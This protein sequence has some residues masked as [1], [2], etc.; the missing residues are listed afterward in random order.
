MKLLYISVVPVDFDNIAGVQRKVLSQARAFAKLGMDVGLLIRSKGRIMLYDIV[1]ER[2]INEYKG[3][4]KYDIYNRAKGIIGDYSCAYIRYP[5]SDPMFISL[6]KS[7]RK[8]GT[9]V[10]VEIPT[11]PYDRQ[12]RKSIRKRL[13]DGIDKMFRK[14]LKRYVGGICTYSLDNEIY[15]IKT[16]K[17]INGFDFAS[18][19]PSTVFTNVKECINMIAVSGMHLLHG[20][21]RMIEGLGQYYK[22]GGTRNLVLHVVGS[23]E[24]EQEWKAL[25]NKLGMEKHVIFH[26][27]QFG[28]DLVK[29]Y[30]NQAIGVNSLAIQREGLERESTLK[31][32]EYG[33]YGLPV[34]SSSY[35]DAFSEKGND[36]YVLRVPANDSPINID[37]LI[38][39]VDDL[40]SGKELEQLRSEIRSDAQAVCDMSITMK[41][42]ADY[43]NYSEV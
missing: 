26:G 3:T 36:T 27:R 10:V 41:P 2:I 34:I 8:C 13:L 15:G 32:K 16:I 17:T 20:Y 21:D 6:L 18:V 14:N 38:A 37:D 23:G 4:S 19:S 9:K 1:Q 7:C 25:V 5:M 29:C 42:I 35:V 30:S 22:N 39:F 31:T 24:I 43:F 28:K 12:I 11:Y 40:Y 33:A